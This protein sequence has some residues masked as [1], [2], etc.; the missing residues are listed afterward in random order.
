[1]KMEMK[2]MS[3][4]YLYAYRIKDEK[5]NS[6]K[7][8]MTTQ[9][10]VEEY[11][12]K[13]VQGKNTKD[14]L[15]KQ[16][17]DIRFIGECPVKDHDIHKYLKKIGLEK[18]DRD[19]EWFDFGNKDP[20]T[21]LTKLIESL[22]KKNFE[23]FLELVE[24]LTRTKSFKP[25]EYQENIINKTIEYYANPINADYQG[26]L[27]N[28]KM[29]GGKCFM[30]FELIKKLALEKVLIVS[31][32]VAVIDSWRRECEEHI[33]FKDF[34][35]KETKEGIDDNMP[36]SN[37][38]KTE[39]YFVSGQDLF[40]KKNQKLKEKNEWIFSEKWDM[41]ICDEYHYG[42]H[43]HK[44]KVG[45][46]SVK[47]N[48]IDDTYESELSQE[49][50]QENDI[51]GVINLP[52]AKK[53]LYLSGTPFRSLENGEFSEDQIATWTYQEEQEK[54]EEL[55]NKFGKSNENYLV[56]MP[57]MNIMSYH[58]DDDIISKMKNIES[59][60]FDLNNFFK[61]TKDGF[62]NEQEVQK[63]VDSLYN[64]YNSNEQ[65]SQENRTKKSV[66]TDLGNKING[67]MWYLSSVNSC[68]AMEKLLQ[69]DSYFKDFLIY[70]AAGSDTDI[71]EKVLK[72]FYDK[73]AATKKDKFIILSCGK[74]NT[75]VTIKELQA[76]FLLSDLQSIETYFQLIFRAQS[77][78]KENNKQECYVFDWAISRTLR[79]VENYIDRQAKDDG[80]KKDAQIC[81]LLKCLPI[82]AFKD[83]KMELLNVSDF[84]N[85]A[86]EGIEM[87]L[88]RRI[89]KRKTLNLSNSILQ[90]IYNNKA[91]LD[92]LMKIE[93]YK[94][95]DKSV[96]VRIKQNNELS[97]AKRNGDNDKEKKVRE[98]IG[99]T[100]KEKDSLVNKL[101]HINNQLLTLL[102]ATEY[103]EKTLTDVIEMADPNYFFEMVGLQKH[104]Y[105]ILTTI[106]LF[107]KDELNAAIM[108]FRR[109]EDISLQKI[110]F[111]YTVQYGDDENEKI[112]LFNKTIDL[113]ALKKIGYSNANEIEKL[114]KAMG[115][116]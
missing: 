86:H 56:Y 11:I 52:D 2:T 15:N 45:K 76:I 46:I 23:E 75:G 71:G 105:Y 17:L 33:D 78:W 10:D 7:V 39:I 72:D 26:Y 28:V 115:V 40:G 101:L 29:R 57:K 54:K 110:K 84:Y 5:A 100:D 14:W 27:W 95:F 43:R 92:E 60:E 47:E 107:N 77:P 68:K 65:F 13:N 53:Y 114:K 51:V 109:L 82:L 31:F 50:N 36:S 44:N 69:K 3:K 22:N 24:G 74:L 93:A 61:A 83:G 81:E 16:E 55:E 90:E 103:R 8:G 80:N 91:L 97:K 108:E 67:S 64:K 48:A 1:M 113:K 94:N 85:F 89:T 111:K 20:N 38:A 37:K 12:R 79:L 63:F 73:K 88:V 98:S 112:G 106:G 59:N 49:L 96:S 9:K 30:A 99:K 21:T 58:I 70:R 41:V 4:I 62:E 34:I 25:H 116:S 104:L 18:I 35:F 87:A 19:H 66:Y 32:K 6:Y 42:L 102:Y